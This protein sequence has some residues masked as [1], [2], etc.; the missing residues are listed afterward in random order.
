M[1]VQA[2]PK[3]VVAQSKCSSGDVI[4]NGAAFQAE[5]RISR[6]AHTVVGDPSPL[7]CAG[8]RDDAPSKA[9]GL[10]QRHDPRNKNLRGT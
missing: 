3:R 5:G 4:L 7:N 8:L 2:D 6:A 1:R 10:K 9:A